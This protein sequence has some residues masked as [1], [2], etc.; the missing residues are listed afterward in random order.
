ME[1]VVALTAVL[2][3]AVLKSL[4]IKN[5]GGFLRIKKNDSDIRESKER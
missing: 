1:I 2:F 3:V 5:Q 4:F